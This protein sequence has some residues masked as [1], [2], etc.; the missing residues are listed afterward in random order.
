MR[1]WHLFIIV[2]FPYHSFCQQVL[3][4]EQISRLADAGKVYGY[5][6]YFHPFLQYKN[7]NWDSAFAAN[8]EGIIRAKDK[9]EYATIMQHLLSSIN[10]HL[11]SV[12]DIP[13]EDSTYQIQLTSHNIKD[14]ILYIYLNDAAAYAPGHPDNVYDRVQLAL[15]NITL[16]KGI[17]FDMRRPP[18]SKYITSVHPGTA[19]DWS[20]SYFQG[21]VSMPSYRSI[22]YFSLYESFFKQ[23]MHFTVNGS[24]T[25]I[26]PLVFIVANEEQVP[27][28][29]IELQKKGLAAIVQ[30][31]GKVLQPGKSIS[32]YI[33]DSVLIKMRVA[34]AVNADGSLL[35]VNPDETY[36]SE[37]NSSALSKAEGLINTEFNRSKR[38]IEYYQPISKH[39]SGFPSGNS[40]PSLGYRMLAAGKI[41]A[42][43][44]NYFPNKKIMD[45]EWEGS[46]RKSIPKFIIAQD[47]LQY[48]RAVAELYANIN[49]SHGFISMGGEGF[50]LRLNPIIQGR[51]NFIPPVFTRVIE[52]KVVIYDYYNDSICKVLGINKGDVIVSI[53]GKD[54]INLI[55]QAR[56]YQ[57]ASNKASQ[58][59]FLGSF[60]L[61]ARQG[62]KVKLALKDSRGKIKNVNMPVLK[63]FNGNFSSDDYA[64]RMYLLHEKPT[65]KLITNEIGYADLTSPLQQKDIDSMFRIFKNTNSLI[66]DM[67][68]Y[69]HYAA[70]D[71][72][73]HL[74]KKKNVVSARFLTST[75]S[76][77]NVKDFNNFESFIDIV[78]THTASQHINFG[79]IQWT[80]QGKIVMLYNEIAQ[81]AAEH[82]GLVLKAICGATFIGSHTAGANGALVNF[83]IP[84][85]IS[86]WFSGENVS[87]PDGTPLQRTGLKPDIFVK[88][89]IKGI[90]AG[91]DE[92]LDRAI[93]YLQT[94]Q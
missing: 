51:G 4:S 3:T 92:V 65:F 57:P 39:L 9:E 62:Q 41:F 19:V 58:N 14:S 72:I 76:S 55:E 88:P 73:T 27:L 8:V 29:A 79:N 91:K 37:L 75:P 42:V 47:S 15:Q 13:K 86:L 12:I 54:P 25:K 59:F 22:S 83:N 20:T 32:F 81:S 5:I 84:G 82:N 10:D 68:G 38:V 45:K 66:F 77:P 7:I 48:M 33:Y 71:F 53:N 6:K 30:E 60:L 69:P 56:K 31:E 35:V 49:D 11:T 1:I 34:D 89:T 24:A 74:A 36:S 46:Y 80:Y 64:T 50:S 67:R 87:Y 44:D 18:Q 2:T 78:E 61:F 70:S 40:Y 26:V 43:I 21:D 85:N 90:Q 93:K 52:N 16:V 94:G 23:T 28:L 17:I 63:E